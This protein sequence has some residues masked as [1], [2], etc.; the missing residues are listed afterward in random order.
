MSTYDVRVYQILTNKNAKSNSYSVRWKVAGAPH[1]DT[2]ATRAL[3]E[4]FRSKLVVAQR[5]GV[6]FDEASGLPEPMARELN[7]RSWYDHAVA[8][9]DMKWARS[10]AKHRKNVAE[11]LATV[12]PVL[13]ATDRGAPDDETM[14]AALYGWVFNKTRRDAGAPP[15]RLAGAVRWLQAN[16]VSLTALTDASLVRKALD[17]LA[18]RLDGKPAAASTVNRKRAAFSGVL[19][20]AVELRLLE[21]HPLDL[22][23]WEAPKNDDRVD[24]GVVVNP[25]QARTLLAAVR[26]KAPDLEAFFAC[27]YY[28]ALRPEEALHLRDDEFE[29]PARTGAWGWFHLTGATVAVG[30]GWGDGEGVTEDRELKHRAKTA[31]RDVPIH[32]ELAEIL[33]RHVD[34]FGT[35]PDGKLFV[36]RRGP[37]GRWVPTL[38]RPIPN[39][40]YTSVWR[41]AREQALTPAQRRSPLARVPYHLRHA[42]VSTWLNA[43][44]PAT[45]VADWAGHS[46]HVLLKVYAKCIDGQTDEA[47]RRIEAALAPA[48]PE[49]RTTGARRRNAD[50]YTTQRVRSTRIR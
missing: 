25:D 37:G 28:A 30:N 41:G 9:V 29:R 32:P 14:R 35:G 6:P 21:T 42:A 11:A 36:N 27:M 7:A 17:M 26:E 44:V 1:R 12:T 31:T 10:A 22:V 50:T 20:Y 13:L 19:K 40:T 23:S 43:G 18:L 16:T 48:H 34:R 33:T 49:R 3:A 38:G 24:R 45:Q 2:F 15:D 4:S 47:L 46:V 39:N 5:E 8:Y